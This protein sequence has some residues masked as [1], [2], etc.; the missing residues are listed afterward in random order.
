MKRPTI[1]RAMILVALAAVPF[2]IL[3]RRNRFQGL[4]ADHVSEQIRLLKQMETSSGSMTDPFYPL[5]PFHN[6]MIDKYERA[7]RHPWLWAEADPPE[8]K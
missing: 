1:Q 4:T 7:A 8:P 3:E 2:T 5:A 6:K